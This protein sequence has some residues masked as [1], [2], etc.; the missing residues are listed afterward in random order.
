MSNT[1]GKS[2]LSGD[3][4]LR[5]ALNQLLQETPTTDCR[6]L[7]ELTD[8]AQEALTP[9]ARLNSRS[10]IE[11]C[12][13]CA[14]TVSDLRKALL[15]VLKLHRSL[16]GWYGPLLA[17]LRWMRPEMRH[18][19]KGHIARCARCAGRTEKLQAIFSPGATLALGGVGVF[20]VMLCLS[21]LKP[22]VPGLVEKGTGDS[23][24]T[25]KGLTHLPDQ[26]NWPTAVPLLEN[27]L[28]PHKHIDEIEKYWLQ[29]LDAHP[30]SLAA[31]EA[32]ARIYDQ[33]AKAATDP[34]RKAGWKEKADA[35]RAKLV[36]LVTARSRP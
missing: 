8:Y 34:R 21:S 29:I 23:Y 35:E 14:S 17:Y 5:Q 30:D 15:P 18:L 24:E 12:P 22:V 10:H 11:V 16:G 28:Y 20:L 36:E 6:P 4:Y 2:E 31:H 33:N 7:E 27:Y 1:M 19:W 9:E 13:L 25:P 26:A 32:L 3:R